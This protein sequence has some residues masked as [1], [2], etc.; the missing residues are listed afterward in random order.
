M[1]VKLD[2]LL[3]SFFFILL[4]NKV[5]YK[6]KYFTLQHDKVMLCDRLGVCF[7]ILG[8]NLNSCFRPHS[9]PSVVIFL[10]PGILRHNGSLPNLIGSPDTALLINKKH[11]MSYTNNISMLYRYY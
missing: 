4:T 2:K 7:D 8:R 10:N 9:T 11:A 6:L 3:V 5:N 1:K